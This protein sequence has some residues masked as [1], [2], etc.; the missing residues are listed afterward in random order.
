M[1]VKILLIILTLFILTQL[2]P[3]KIIEGNTSYQPY[4]E[5]KEDP[6]FVATKNAANIVYL[7][8]QLDEI[9]GLKDMVYDLSAQVQANAVGITQVSQ[10]IGNAAAQLTG[11]DGSP[12]TEDEAQD[13]TNNIPEITGA[14]GYS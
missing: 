6:L 11:T 8:E 4:D 9:Q 3:N 5:L 13:M 10:E 2:Y 14:D 12:T 1:L 7:K